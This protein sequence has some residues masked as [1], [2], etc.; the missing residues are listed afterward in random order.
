MSVTLAIDPALVEELTV[1]AAGPYDVGGKDDAGTGTEAA[2]DFLDRLRAV[3]ETHPVMALPYG[4]VDLDALDAAGLTGV[5]VRSLPG[6]PSASD[7]AEDG[8]AAGSPAA[9]STPAE[10]GADTAGDGRHRSSAPGS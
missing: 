10:D 9:P 8:P 3:A 7:E 4:D 2:V 1:M 6:T 5:L